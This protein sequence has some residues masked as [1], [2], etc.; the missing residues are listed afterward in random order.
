[1]F[2]QL[3]PAVGLALGLAAA[4]VSLPAEAQELMGH[5]PHSYRGG[6]AWESEDTGAMPG[7]GCVDVLV[8]T[9]GRLV[10]HLAHTQG[11]TLEHLKFLVSQIVIVSYT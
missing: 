3:C 11:F 6:S 5:S 8:A 10:A 7:Q 9:P 1:M 2:A 4:Q